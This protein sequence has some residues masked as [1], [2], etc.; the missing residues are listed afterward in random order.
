MLYYIN[1]TFYKSLKVDA[2]YM[3]NLLLFLLLVIG[4]AIIFFIMALR[5]TRNLKDA[6]YEWKKAMLEWR[7]L[8]IPGL[9]FLLVLLLVSYT[10]GR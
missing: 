8:A 9:I 7:N 1:K 4:Y 10:I 6:F 5:D 2:I 3:D